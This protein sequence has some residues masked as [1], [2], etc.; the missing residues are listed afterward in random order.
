MPTSSQSP[1]RLRMANLFP[2]ES[3]NCTLTVY[4]A[5]KDIW[6]ERINI[7]VDIYE[8]EVP[9]IKPDQPYD[10]Q[11]R[12]FTK[13]FRTFSFSTAECISVCDRKHITC[14]TISFSTGDLLT[15]FSQIKI[16]VQL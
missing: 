15:F 2:G 10:I 4:Y 14:V 1:I 9:R 16:S 12:R 8:G 7:P 13:E 3:Y 11:F 6:P 5:R